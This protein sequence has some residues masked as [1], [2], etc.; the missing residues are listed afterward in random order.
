MNMSRDATT[1]SNC[2]LPDELPT[3]ITTNTQT[4][5]ETCVLN[6][7]HKALEEHLGINP[8]EQSVLDRC[9]LREL[10]IAQQN[11]KHLSQVAPA[12]IILLQSGA[13]WNSDALLDDRKTPYHVICESSGDHHE[14]LELM[15]KSSRQTIINAQDVYKHTALLYAMRLANINCLK[16]LINNEA[17]VNIEFNRY[18]PSITATPPPQWS[19][20]LES[21]ENLSCNKNRTAIKEKLDIFNLLLDSGADI[22]KSSFRY[23]MSPLML[24]VDYGN[25]YCIEKLIEKGARLDVLGYDELYAWPKIAVLGNVKLLKCMFNYGIDK[26]STDLNGYSVL[27]WVV[28]SGNVKA[29]R[30]LLYLGVAIPSYETEVREANCELWQKNGVITC[31]KQEDRDPCMQAIRFNRLRIVK[32][33]KDYG[34]TICEL[35]TALRCAVINNS[36]D[37]ASYLLK[38]YIYNLN[39]E[40]SQNVF[41]YQSRYIYTLLTEPRFVFTSKITKLLLDHGADPAQPMTTKTSVNAIMTTI[42]HGNLKIIAQYIRSGVDINVRSYDHLYK[43]ILPFEAS[44]LRGYHNVAEMLLISG[45]SC[46]VFSLDN[47]HKFKRNL[48]PEVETLLMEWNVLENNVTPLKQRCR[49]VILNH[50]SPRADM[51]IEMLPLPRCLIKFLSISEIDDIVDAYNEADRN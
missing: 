42:P 18:H 48:K 24:A 9:L 1:E 8:V 39:F 40:Y 37:V 35:F 27:W 34:S 22:D 28:V 46:G 51:K 16:C 19:P 45:C 29:V 17:D 38:K 3:R 11:V 44:V 25:V 41:R 21:I 47:N 10:Q 12:L 26:D 43:K 7:D 50:L 20:F 14:L 15:I 33:L 4:F 49:C 2:S 31:L 6:V 13:K 36:V 5:L 32:L 30:Y 23:Q